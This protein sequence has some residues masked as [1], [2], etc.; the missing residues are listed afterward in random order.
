MKKF[1][2]NS[3]IASI[4]SFGIVC[5]SSASA[6]KINE[7]NHMIVIK[8]PVPIIVRQD[9]PDYYKK[10]AKSKRRKS[11]YEESQL[12]KCIMIN[13][14]ESTASDQWKEK[15]SKL[16]GLIKS[17]EENAII[18][19]SID[20]KTIEEINR[21]LEDLR[22]LKTKS[23]FKVG[24]FEKIPLNTTD[25]ISEL[26]KNSGELLKHLKYCEIYS[27]DNLLKEEYSIFYNLIDIC[28]RNM[29]NSS[30]IKVK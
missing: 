30:L 2:L 3:I 5:S 21:R 8:G 6:S 16:E 27:F 12:G 22:G 28:L 1:K 23:S 29:D 15:S 18:K 20:L 25:F 14:Y 13:N 10:A 26:E 17:C 9:V 7:K 11:F 19:K 24:K 4:L